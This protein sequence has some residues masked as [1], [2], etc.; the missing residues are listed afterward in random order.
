MAR[1]IHRMLYLVSKSLHARM[2]SRLD[3]FTTFVVTIDGYFLLPLIF[4]SPN[5]TGEP[6]LGKSSE[7]LLSFLLFLLSFCC[8]SIKAPKTSRLTAQIVLR[9]TMDD[10]N[11]GST[12]VMARPQ[13]FLNAAVPR[14]SIRG[15]VHVLLLTSTIDI[16]E[17]G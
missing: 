4:L 10:V 3:T 6:A 9:V 12:V 17:R 16:V 14:I 13:S 5:P 2:F 7:S 1:P 11:M 8:S 15:F